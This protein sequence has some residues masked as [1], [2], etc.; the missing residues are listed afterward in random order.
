M[1]IFE[2]I[3]KKRIKVH[4]YSQGFWRCKVMKSYNFNKKKNQKYLNF[5]IFVMIFFPTFT[6]LTMAS[7]LQKKIFFPLTRYKCWWGILNR[8]IL[9]FFRLTLYN[10]IIIVF[11]WMSF[12]RPI[13]VEFS[14]E[15]FTGHLYL[16]RCKSADI[17][18]NQLAMLRSRKISNI[19]ESAD[20]AKVEVIPPRKSSFRF[21]TTNI[22]FS[23]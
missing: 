2:I 17:G 4:D 3:S 19:E 9:F 22:H 6:A 1:F 10:C 20:V 8:C 7:K 21:S 23:I 14:K 15:S 13:C 16:E 18:V 5:K 12:G 11:A